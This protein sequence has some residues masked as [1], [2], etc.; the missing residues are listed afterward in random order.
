MINHRID[1]HLTPINFKTHTILETKNKAL[2]VTRRQFPILLA[3]AMTIHKSQG[4][5]FDRVAI[6]MTPK[7]SRSL[8]YVA[9][10]RVTSANGLYILNGY[11]PPTQVKDDDPLQKELKR[12]ESIRSEPMFAFLHKNDG[13]YGY[14]FMYHNVQSLH[15]HEKDIACDASFMHSDILLFAETWTIPKDNIN[16]P[17]FHRA[18]EIHSSTNGK[19]KPSGVSIYVKEGIKIQSIHNYP[20][21]EKGIHVSVVYL[22]KNIRFAVLYA[23]PGSSLDD[24]SDAVYESVGDD[25]EDYKT[26][27]AGDFNTN[28]STDEGK[29]FCDVLR[30][31]YW[32]ELKTNPAYWT[33][34]QQTSID[35]VFSTHDLKCCGVYESLFSYHIPLYGRM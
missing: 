31:V 34:R 21:Y 16:F 30:N 17:N 2:K 29:I 20:N 7:M 9:F 14:Q 3:E 25:C 26:V 6:G 8:Q 28:M 22:M 15:A 1:P 11:Y 5:T 13:N 10:S 27:L 12:L 18:S 32:L 19:R 24:I 23:K 33:T 35:A 4:C